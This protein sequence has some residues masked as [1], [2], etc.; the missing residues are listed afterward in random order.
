MHF[1]KCFWAQFLAEA[2]GVILEKFKIFPIISLKYAG[3]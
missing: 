1:L 3:S 2:L